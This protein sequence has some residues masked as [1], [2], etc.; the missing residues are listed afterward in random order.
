MSLPIAPQDIRDA[1][2]EFASTSLAPD[3]FLQQ[4]IDDADLE[5]EPT[6]WGSRA[7]LAEKYLAAHYATLRLRKNGVAGPQTGTRVGDVAVQYAMPVSSLVGMGL[8]PGLATTSYGLN[9]AR[10]IKIAAFGIAT[11]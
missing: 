7:E 8:D 4:C 5:I 1:F 9:Y 10:L 2:P 3:P 6:A 11:T